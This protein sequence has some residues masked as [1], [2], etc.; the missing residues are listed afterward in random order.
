MHAQAADNTSPRGV[1]GP[2]RLVGAVSLLAI[3]ASAVFMFARLDVKPFWVDEAIA[4]LPARS[5][6][7]DGVPRNP[8]DLDFM[9]FQLE[10]SIWDP[11]APL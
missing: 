8:F 6:L 5:I 10:D 11:S 3:L 2:D 9:A 4:V 1:T 7:T